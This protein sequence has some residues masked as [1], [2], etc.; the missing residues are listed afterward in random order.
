MFCHFNGMC[1]PCPG[2][3]MNELEYKL[4]YG[5]PTKSDLL[6]A[7]GVLSA[8]GQMVRDPVSKRQKVIAELR[9]GPTP[10]AAVS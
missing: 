4:R 9:K 10:R 7:A 6:S 3:H 8:Y 5:T 1:W 2:E